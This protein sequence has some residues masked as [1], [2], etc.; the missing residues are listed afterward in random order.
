MTKINY[1]KVLVIELSSNY[2]LKRFQTRN[3]SK[4]RKLCDHLNNG[5]AFAGLTPTFFLKKNE[6]LESLLKTSLKTSC[7]I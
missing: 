2:V 6:Q 1:N 7:N 5:G 3:K 4:A